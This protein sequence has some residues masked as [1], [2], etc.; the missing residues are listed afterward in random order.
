MFKGDWCDI[1]TE[2]T[3]AQTGSLAMVKVRWSLPLF[4]P[5]LISG[6]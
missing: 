6:R 3:L 5:E 1:V 2:F 4:F